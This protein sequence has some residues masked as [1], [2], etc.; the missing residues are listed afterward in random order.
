MSYFKQ[1][2]GGHR[3]SQYVN[4]VAIDPFPEQSGTPEDSYRLMLSFKKQLARAGVHKPF[5][6]NEINYGIAGAHDPTT[7][8]Y[9]MATQQSYVIR[10]YALSAAAEMEKTFWLAWS[11]NAELG[12]QMSDSNGA[13]LPTATSYEVVR[14][15]LNATD[16]KGCVTNKSG[17]WTCTAKAGPEVRRIYWKPSGSATI[18]TPSST[19]R[20]E[21]QDGAVSTRVGAYTTR[22]TYKPIMVASRK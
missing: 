15:W 7:S 19:L 5:W 17:L 20:L 1:A 4:A 18:K 22:V 10:T 13:A 6:N 12:V 21:N 11:P 2:I 8:K 14:T 3:V 16:F 9:S